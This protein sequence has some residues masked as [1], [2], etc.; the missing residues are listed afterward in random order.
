MKHVLGLLNYPD[1]HYPLALLTL[2]SGPVATTLFPVFSKFS[3]EAEEAKRM[4]KL[5]GKSI[6]QP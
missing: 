3:A 6:P 5:F 2:L 4:F 1:F